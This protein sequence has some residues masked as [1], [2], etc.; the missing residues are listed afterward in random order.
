MHE[1]LGGGT[2]NSRAKSIR[3]LPVIAS[4]AG[5]GLLEFLVE[6]SFAIHI[7]IKDQ[8]LPCKFTNAASLSLYQKVLS[9]KYFS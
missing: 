8:Q 7:E 9:V 6:A 4:D 5:N 3:N 1:A 2:V